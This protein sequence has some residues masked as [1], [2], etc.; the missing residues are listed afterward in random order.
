[1]T[2][3]ADEYR[4]ALR[5]HPPGRRHH[6]DVRQ[7]PGGIHCDLVRPL[8]LNPP[9]VSFNITHTSSSIA[10]LTKAPSVAVHLICEEQL[11]IARRFSASADQ[12]FAEPVTWEPASTGGRCS[13][14][15]RRGCG[16]ELTRLIP[17][18]FPLVVA[19]VT[20][21]L[22]QRGQGAAAVP[23]RPI[24]LCACAGRLRRQRSLRAHAIAWARLTA[25]YLRGMCLTCD[26][27]VPSV[28]TSRSAMA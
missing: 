25:P 17:A 22:L 23:R 28:M 24:P 18:G 3:S 10:A 21:A 16:A 20:D 7:R 15:H 14:T 6:P 19:R 9:L 1:M 12:R 13:Q 26:F 4:S 8:S 11:E 5:R 2:V 27:T